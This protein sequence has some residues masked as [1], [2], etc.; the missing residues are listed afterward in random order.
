MLLE[1]RKDELVVWFDGVMQ[2]LFDDTTVIDVL[3]KTFALQ[4]E[5]MD[6]EAFEILYKTHI[7]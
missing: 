2:K 5:V 3:V 6:E 7:G 1:H 4:L